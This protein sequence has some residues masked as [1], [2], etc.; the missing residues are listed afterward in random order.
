MK[1]TLAQ[2]KKSKPSW[3]SLG[4]GKYFTDHMLVMEYKDGAWGECEIKPFDNFSMHPATAVLH[5]GQ[6]IF[7]GLKAYKGKDGKVSLFRAK[8]NFLRMNKTAQ[9]M[10]MPPVDIDK[11]MEALKELIKI[12]S[13]W[14]P[15]AEGTS[16]Y[17]RPAMIAKDEFL[18]VKPSS[19]YLFFIILSPVGSYYATGLKPCSIMIEDYYVRAAIGGTGEAKCMGNYAASL[20]AAKI[21]HD[22][23]YEQVLWLDAAEKKYI[24]EVGAMNIFFVLGDTVVTPKLV[25]S[26]L[27][28]ITRDSAIQALKADGIKV[29][30]RRISVEE[31]EQ[32]YKSGQLKESFGTGT[33]AVISPVG[34]IGI[35]G[36]DWIINNNEMGPI[37]A[38]LYE[39]ITS[40]QNR[41]VADPFGWVTMV[42]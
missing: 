10:C 27:P 15:T 12:D 18:G 35:K 30:E 21:A 19:T 38:K 16:L 32:A 4:F 22:K 23:G 41:K 6:G 11:V 24:E 14:I 17:I 39:R 26:I 5:Y 40:I 28:G 9:R 36:T 3:D 2:N 25:G 34:K 1:V 42:E 31:L 7:E 37:T 8:D 33:A 29:E 20:L 13:D